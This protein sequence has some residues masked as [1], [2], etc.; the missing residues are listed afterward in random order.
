M[1][2]RDDLVRIFRGRKTMAQPQ[3]SPVQSMISLLARAIAAGRAP[4]KP[5][6]APDDAAGQGKA[7]TLLREAMEAGRQP[8][9][10]PA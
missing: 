4:G 7:G 1:E 8:S 10:Q 6:R 3:T 5:D 9:G 2:D